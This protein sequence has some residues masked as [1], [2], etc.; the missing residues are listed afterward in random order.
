MGQFEWLHGWGMLFPT[1]MHYLI[2]EIPV[3]KLDT[4]FMLLFKKG[5]RIPV[6][7]HGL[8]LLFLVVQNT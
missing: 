8:L 4:L 5:P 7:E 2:M 1:D 3:P 6:K